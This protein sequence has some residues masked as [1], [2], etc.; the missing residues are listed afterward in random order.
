MGAACAEGAATRGN[1]GSACMSCWS[2]HAALPAAAADHFKA[3]QSPK[4]V[5]VSAPPTNKHCL[6]RRS[7]FPFVGLG[8]GKVQH[9]LSASL[10]AITMTGIA[11]PAHLLPPPASQ[12]A[13]PCPGVPGCACA[14]VHPGGSPHPETAAWLHTYTGKE[15]GVR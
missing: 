15:G 10:L 8:S 2:M 13:L 5:V 4:F 9:P 14:S 1:W 11:Y 6:R 3:P 12:G 7:T